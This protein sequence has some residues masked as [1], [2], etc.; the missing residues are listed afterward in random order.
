[1]AKL[2]REFQMRCDPA[3]AQA[4]FVRDVVPALYRAGEFVV[5]EETAGELHLSDGATGTRGLADPDGYYALRRDLARR[6]TVGFGAEATGTHVSITGHA[7]REIRDAI[8][9]LGTPGHWPETAND[10]HD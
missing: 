8:D 2:D 5:Y 10:P 1:M 4:M 9:K 6:I 3:Q 7:E